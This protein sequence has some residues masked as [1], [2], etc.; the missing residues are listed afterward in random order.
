[1]L[2]LPPCHRPRRLTLARRTVEQV[3]GSRVAPDALQPLVNAADKWRAIDDVLL[4]DDDD[5]PLPPEPEA[6]A[7][8]RKAAVAAMVEWVLSDPSLHPLQTATQH[9]TDAMAHNDNAAL[10]EP[11]AAVWDALAR[12]LDEG[13]DQVGLQSLLNLWADATGGPR[14]TITVFHNLP[15]LP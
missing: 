3:F 9:L 10:A 12:A 13:L 11:L 14:I 15:S 6:S 2:A 1:V 5:E 4:R 7:A 8:E